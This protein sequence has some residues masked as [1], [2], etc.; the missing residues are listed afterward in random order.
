[1]SLKEKHEQILAEFSPFEDA[2]ERFQYVI[3]RAK[4]AP[5]LA[6]EFIRDEFLV[7][8]CTSQLWLVCSFENKIC[9]FRCDA[10]ALI[11]KGIAA[12]VCDFFDGETPE[13][14]L[15]NNADFLAAV[16]IDQHLSPNRRNGLANLVKRIH[17][18]AK[19]CI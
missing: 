12:L 9:K 3:D 2:Q 11:V 15:E 6:P 4:D 5:K 19:A 10:D 1:M 17:S 18:F 8:G 13:E 16:G 14:I 7:Q